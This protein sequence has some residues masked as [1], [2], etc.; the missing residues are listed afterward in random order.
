MKLIINGM[1]MNGMTGNDVNIA[2]FC[3]AQYRYA[4]VLAETIIKDY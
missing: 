2:S 1:L 4:S 3:L